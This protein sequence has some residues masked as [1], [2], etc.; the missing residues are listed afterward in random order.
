MVGRLKVGDKGTIPVKVTL[1]D[2]TERWVTFTI[3]GYPHPITMHDPPIT[4][5]EPISP[6]RRKKG[7]EHQGPP[8]PRGLK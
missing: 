3:Q 6:T 8:S 4:V 5:T 1:L 7:A 2:V